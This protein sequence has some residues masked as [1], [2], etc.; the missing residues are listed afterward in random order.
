MADADTVTSE[1]LDVHVCFKR[2][3]QCS[4]TLQLEKSNQQLFSQAAAGF[5][6][7]ASPHIVVL[8]N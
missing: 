5:Q 8:A 7:F 3:L 4:I 1:M 6:I 2:V